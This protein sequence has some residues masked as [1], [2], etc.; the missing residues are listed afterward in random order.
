MGEIAIDSFFDSLFIIF[1]EIKL[2]DI[3]A[4]EYIESIHNLVVA[5]T[6]GSSIF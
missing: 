2:P 4:S 1:L 6:V 3:D 5:F